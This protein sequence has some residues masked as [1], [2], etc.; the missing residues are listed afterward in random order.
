MPSQLLSGIRSADKSPDKLSFAKGNLPLQKY[1]QAA[2]EILP[3]KMPDSGT[4]G[5]LM[6]SGLL[7]AGLTAGTDLGTTGLLMGGLAAARNLYRPGMTNFINAIGG[8]RPRFMRSMGGFQLP[9]GLSYLSRASG[10]I[11][12]GLLGPRMRQE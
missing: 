5:R 8:R 1:A 6:R 3:S 2:Q 9:P 4:P 7:G 12:M 11:G 10:P